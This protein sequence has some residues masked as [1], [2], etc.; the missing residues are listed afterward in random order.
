MDPK[1][2]WHGCCNTFL[3]IIKYDNPP[4]PEINQILTYWRKSEKYIWNEKVIHE[5]VILKET[6]N[7]LKWIHQ[8][9]IDDIWR[10]I[11][12]KKDEKTNNYI[13]EYYDKK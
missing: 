12:F 5:R 7:E 9:K 4:I 13:I 10:D 11:R 2:I 3:P 6:G 1:N 8:F